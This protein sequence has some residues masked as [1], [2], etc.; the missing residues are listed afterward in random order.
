MEDEL[1]VV[2]LD[3][4][5]DERL[6]GCLL[7]DF[8]SDFPDPSFLGPAAS[9]LCLRLAFRASIKSMT[10]VFFSSGANFTSLPS[11]LS[12]IASIRRSL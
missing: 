7:V 10:L 12:S 4:D 3:L 5:L 9:L 2:D 6:A 8:V 11:T 1:R